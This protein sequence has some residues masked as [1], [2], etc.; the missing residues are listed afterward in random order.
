M[1]IYKAQYVYFEEDLEDEWEDPTT[2]EE[3]EDE[4]DVAAF[5]PEGWREYAIEKWGVNHLRDDWPRGYKPFFWPSD[6]PIYRS[7][8]SAQA[9]VDLI[10]HWGA[11][12]VLLEA[13]VE[14]IPVEVANKRRKA[15]KV[16]DRLNRKLDEADA[17]AQELRALT[18][19]DD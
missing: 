11:A 15:Q 4:E 10:E 3:F 19:G 13:D 16:R 5:E 18:K 9:R 6:R 14:W 12:A 8:S 2:I 7:R 17:I 1:R